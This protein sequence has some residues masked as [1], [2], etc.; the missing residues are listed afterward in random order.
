MH[1]KVLNGTHK[2]HVY[3]YT[4]SGL[5]LSLSHDLELIAG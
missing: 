3:T 5:S 4:Q 1:V 2:L